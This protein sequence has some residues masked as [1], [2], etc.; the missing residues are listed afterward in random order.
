MS[1]QLSPEQFRTMIFYDWK[2]ALTYKDCHTCLVQAWGGGSNA[3]S[4]HTVFNCFHEFQRNQFTLQHAPRP[5]RPSTS[6]TEHTIDA[7]RKIIEED[8]HSTYQ[9]RELILGISS[10]AISSIIHDYLNLRKVCAGW[11]PYT[12]ADDQKQLRVQFCGHSLKRFEENRSGRVF[13]I[14]TGDESSFYHY[15]RELKEQ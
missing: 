2:I 8:L 9:Q 5:D 14:R 13:D 10:M 4:D 15:D 7:V 1:F 12:L 6:V 11:V 3:P